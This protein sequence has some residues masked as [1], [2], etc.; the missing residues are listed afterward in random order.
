VPQVA[1][2]LRHAGNIVA[3]AGDQPDA[4]DV[5]FPHGPSGLNGRMIASV[6]PFKP[7][8]SK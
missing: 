5:D 6:V 8:E 2:V 7:M 4:G 3:D 1:E